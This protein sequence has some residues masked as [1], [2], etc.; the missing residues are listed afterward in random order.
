MESCCIWSA[1]QHLIQSHHR[2]IGFSN[3]KNQL[4]HLLAA[5]GPR[6]CNTRSSRI[7]CTY[8]D[9]VRKPPQPSPSSSSSSSSAIQLY[10]QIERLLTETSR[11]S[12]D[13]WGGSKDWSEVEIVLISSQGSWVLK[14]KSSRPK[15]VVHFI[16]GIFVGA[17]PQ[18]TYRLF[19][20]RLAEKGVLVIATPY[21]SGFDYFFIADEVQFKFDRCLRFL[22]ETVQDVPTFGIGHSLGSVI[23]LLIGSRY[24]V[25]R[26]GNILMAF[27]NKV[28]HN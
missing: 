20:E 4:V 6:K 15:S 11:Q 23:H 2:F 8:E 18:L 9:P 21:A 28:L 7:F 17:A 10:N 3:H 1:H 16:G 14:P 13:Y 22:Q 24:A 26:S 5:N 25:Q 12:Q 27:N 19:L